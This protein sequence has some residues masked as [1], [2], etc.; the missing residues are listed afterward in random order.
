MEY[1][2]LIGFLTLVL[3]TILGIG[4]YYSTTAEERLRATQI[5]NYGIKV[6]SSAESVYYSGEP[7]KATINPY[8]PEGVTD[9]K[10]E[11]DVLLDEYSLFI[12]IQL[13]TGENKISFKSQVPIAE[14]GGNPLSH[15]SGIKTIVLK[16]QGDPDYNVLLSE[17]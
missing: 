2:I 16:A 15:S 10:V 13:P 5:Q 8:L 7:S 11:Y 12:T 3:T 6:V 14:S 4:L 17:G 9:I 1:L